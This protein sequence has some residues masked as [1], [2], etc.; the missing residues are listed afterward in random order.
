MTNNKTIIFK[1]WVLV[2]ALQFSGVSC[3]KFLEIPVSPVQI[4]TPNVFSNDATAESAISGLYNLMQ[5]GNLWIFNGGLSI[6]SSLSADEIHRS[7]QNPDYEA[8]EKNS[9]QALNGQIL[10]S[11]MWQPCYR[12]IYHANAI[13]EGLNKSVLVTNDLR[14][15]IMGEVYVIR[16]LNYFYLVNLFGEIPL[17]LST[18]YQENQNMPRTPIDQ[19][20]TQ[21][22]KDLLEAEK[23][24][25]ISYPSDERARPN[26]LVATALMARVYLY[27]KDWN[28]SEQYANEVINSGLYELTTDLNETFLTSSRETLWQFTRESQATVEGSTFI[29]FLSSSVP[30]YVMTEHFINAIEPGDLRKVN[31]INENIRDRQSF[32]YPYKYKQRVITEGNPPQEYSVVLRLAELYLIRAE[33]RAQ[34]EKYADATIDLNIIRNRAGLVNIQP[35]GK[36]ALLAKIYQERR[37]ELFT[38]WGHRWLDLKRLN[39]ADQIL[40]PIK[41]PYWKP[42]AVLYPIPLA[43]IESNPNLNQNSGY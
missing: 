9:L 5:S 34:L 13:L 36:E 7:I 32:Y 40:G 4:E 14:N 29:P 1:L 43:E 2:V 35:E 18:N 21:I 3:R 22:I 27:Q 28:K 11:R 37:V 33:A 38:E 8:F 10:Y 16:A 31:W 39:L 15:Q 41:S 12:S 20:Y 23:L 6:Y 25:S 19:V 17:I 26:K 24:L 30:V 42:T